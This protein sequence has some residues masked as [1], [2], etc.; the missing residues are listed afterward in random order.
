MVLHVLAQHASSN[1]LSCSKFLHPP[2][3]IHKNLPVCHWC[4][5]RMHSLVCRWRKSPSLSL[6]LMACS[7]LSKRSA[8]ASLNEW[9][10]GTTNQLFHGGSHL[11]GNLIGVF[12]MLC[13]SFEPRNLGLCLLR[14]DL[15]LIWFCSAV[16]SQLLS[17]KIC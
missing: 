8:A 3:T 12:L 14:F 2:A 5:H 7:S 10:T 15:F 6:E 11:S 17:L 13:N 16:K 4:R 1:V 9:S